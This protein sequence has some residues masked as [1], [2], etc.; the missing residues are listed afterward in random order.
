MD[1]FAA[2]CIVVNEFGTL[3]VCVILHDVYVDVDLVCLLNSTYL[4]FIYI[5]R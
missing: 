1:I 3:L 4:H 2:A 5:T